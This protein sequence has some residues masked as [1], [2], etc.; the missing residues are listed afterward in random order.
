[1]ATE[2]LHKENVILLG[3]TADFP[4]YQ[5]FKFPIALS[6]TPVSSS[7]MEEATEWPHSFQKGVLE[8]FSSKVLGQLSPF[9]WRKIKICGLCICRQLPAWRSENYFELT[10]QFLIHVLTSGVD[11]SVVQEAG[12]TD[13]TFPGL[14]GNWSEK[15][16]WL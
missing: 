15:T 6:L 9:G 4:C 10:A 8:D 1:M 5:S 12:W 7:Q 2:M 13:N 3:L 11:T 14:R 16:H